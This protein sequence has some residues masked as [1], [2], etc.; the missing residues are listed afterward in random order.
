MR[1]CRAVLGVLSQGEHQ[2]HLRAGRGAA[3][4]RTSAGPFHPADDGAPHADP[5]R[6]YICHV[7]SRAAVP[8]ED[9]ELFG[10]ALDVHGHRSAGVLGGVEHGGPGSGGQCLAALVQFRVGH[11]NQFNRMSVGV[12]DFRGHPAQAFH[13]MVL[14]T[15]P[16]RVQPLPQFPL[17]GA[18]QPDNVLL[19]A[20]PLL[21]QGQGL[22]HRVVQV[23]GNLGSF[24]L[25]DPA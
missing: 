23:G 16:V 5:V 18:G 15:G 17:L 9:F 20:R 24:G 2:A 8:D 4:C 6:R 12:L 10:P 1:L 3:D 22:Q 25:P 19:G 14:G 7:E 13:Q 21:D 11:R